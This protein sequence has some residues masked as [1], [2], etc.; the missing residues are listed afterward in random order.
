MQLLDPTLMKDCPG[1]W[2][3]CRAAAF[4]CQP[5]GACLSCRATSVRIPLFQE[6]CTSRGGS[7][8]VYEH[9]A[10]YFR[11]TLPHGKAFTPASPLHNMLPPQPLSQTDML[12]PRVSLINPKH[13][14]LSQSVLPRDLNL[15]SS[16]QGARGDD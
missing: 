10:H 5:P 4:T 12:I 3:C 1:C 13:T 14:K 9:L 8:E 7:R 11:S 2:Q 16:K 15:R 6:H